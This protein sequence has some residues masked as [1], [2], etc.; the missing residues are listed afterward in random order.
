[1]DAHILI[2]EDDQLQRDML[3]ELVEQ[4]LDYVP[5]VA[6]NGQEAIKLISKDNNYEAIHLIILDI[7]MPIMDGIDTL[8]VIQEDFSHIPVIIL[9]GK[10]TS[11][12]YETCMKFGATDFM[13]K[14]FDVEKII[15]TIQSAVKA[16]LSVKEGQHARE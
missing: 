15:K 6:S 4:K 14:P 12:N 9:T 7:D 3:A 13:T 16:D 5:M 10:S 2:V 11:A 8:K 1:M